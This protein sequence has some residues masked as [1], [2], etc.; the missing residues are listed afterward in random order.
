VGVLGSARLQ[1][2]DPRYQFGREVGAAIAE[3]GWQVMT[4]GYGGVMAA[5]AAGAAAAGGQVI[6]LPMRQ[7]HNLTPD[8]NCAQ[9]LWCDDYPDR[10]RHLLGCDAVVALDGGVGTIAE[11][12]VAWSA[13][14]TEPDSPVLVVAG[15]G[16]PAL[17]AAIG[18]HMVV[19]QDDLA[20]VAIAETAGKVVPAI[21]AAVASHRAAL[22]RG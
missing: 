18:T 15:A 16:W 8:V 11:L 13:R 5:V 6:G 10:L 14:Q 7:W 4:G 9:L 17:L 1:P 22:P 19:A 21:E 20:L 3:R 2:H 12:T